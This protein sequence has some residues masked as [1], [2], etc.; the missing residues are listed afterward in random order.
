LSYKVASLHY[1]P[2]GSAFH[3]SYDLIIR[4]DVARCLYKFSNAPI[5]ATI[6]IVSEDGTNQVASTTVGEKDGWLYLSA[7]GFTFSSPTVKVKLTQEGSPAAATKAV[8]RK[9][10]C[11]KGKVSKVVTT[12]TCPV[13]YKKKLGI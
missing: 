11:V 6:S 10:N 7:N 12:A 9:I 5:S 1:L 8:P 4:S 3:G 2:D 13:G